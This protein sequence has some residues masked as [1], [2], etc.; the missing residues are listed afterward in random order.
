MTFPMPGCLALACRCDQRTPLGP[1]NV[2]GAV[3]VLVFGGFGILG[4]QLRMLRFESL[5]KVL[6]E[7]QAE[8]DMLVVRRLQ[9][10]RS[11]SAALNSS[12]PK[13]RSLPASVF[14][15]QA[16]RVLIDAHAPW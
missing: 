7:D 12:A 13:P 11:L 1:D 8:S 16:M 2:V 14:A 3:F 4:E 10:P 5:G 6:E 15:P 9:V